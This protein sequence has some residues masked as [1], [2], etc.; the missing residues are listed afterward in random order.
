MGRLDS[1]IFLHL[2]SRVGYR[3]CQA[4]DQSIHDLGS[5]LKLSKNF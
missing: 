5:I 4:I 2:R 3:R 1:T